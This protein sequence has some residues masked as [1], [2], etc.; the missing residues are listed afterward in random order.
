AVINAA[1]VRQSAY[2]RN[3]QVGKHAADANRILT[4]LAI[5]K[6]CLLDSGKRATYDA[7]LKERQPAAT[8]SPPVAARIA[9]PVAPLAPSV[10]LDPL[11]AAAMPSP[12]L[13]ANAAARHR[14]ASLF[15]APKRERSQLAWQ[16]PAGIAIAFAIALAAFALWPRNAEEPSRQVADAPRVINGTVPADAATTAPMP[17]PARLRHL[18]YR[19]RFMGKAD[20]HKSTGERKSCSL[21]HRPRWLSVRQ[22]SGA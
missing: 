17:A 12:P 6:T 15:K 3:F 1:V 18:P 14:R 16:L 7:E 20:V 21:G 13:P 10:D 11:T 2:V 5:A 19:R 8:A 22:F 4:E 9:T